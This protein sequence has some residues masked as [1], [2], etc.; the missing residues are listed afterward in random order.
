MD[1]RLRP[2]MFVGQIHRN[3]GVP[4]DFRKVVSLYYNAADRPEAT[5]AFTILS[6]VSPSS[7]FHSYTSI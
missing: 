3:Y 2:A 4:H 1:T 5:H 7:I 6:F